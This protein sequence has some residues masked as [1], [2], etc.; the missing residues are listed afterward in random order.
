LVSFVALSTNKGAKQFKDIYF[1]WFNARKDCARNY[2]STMSDGASEIDLGIS[3][4][5]EAIHAQEK[6]AYVR[7]KRGSCWSHVLIKNALV[8]IS[9]I[10]GNENHRVRVMMLTD[11]K[12]IH[13]CSSD[14]QFNAVADLFKKKYCDHDILSVKTAALSIYKAYLDPN[15]A[16]KNQYAG[17]LPLENMNNCGLESQNKNMKRIV[18]TK[19]PFSRFVDRVVAYLE[20]TSRSYNTAYGPS[21]VIWARGPKADKPMWNKAVMMYQNTKGKTP[22]YKVIKIGDYFLIVRRDE[23]PI[24]F[25]GEGF[26]HFQALREK[27]INN[28]WESSKEFKDFILGNDG[29]LVRTNITTGPYAGC[30]IHCHCDTF[31]REFI[32]EDC[33]FIQLMSNQIKIPNNMLSF[34]VNKKDGVAPLGRPTKV[35]TRFEK[36]T[37]YSDDDEDGVAVEYASPSRPR[38]QNDEGGDFDE[39]ANNM[40]NEQMIK[41]EESDKDSDNDSNSESDNDHTDNKEQGKG[42]NKVS[43]SSSSRVSSNSSNFFLHLWLHIYLWL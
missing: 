6:W 12:V 28:S 32:C 27:F 16:K 37:D 26:A 40:I 15:A 22:L 1:I 41:N 34:K 29:V 21:T 36:E 17:S 10:P 23:N 7:P 18:K 31:T 19:G 39:E 11:F 20:Q 2:R 42:G 5:L 4:A 25:T 3:Q 43:S 8:H 38:R 24:C 14:E 9:K 33:L 35:S 30:I 13:Q